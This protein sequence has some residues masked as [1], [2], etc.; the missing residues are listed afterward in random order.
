M[1]KRPNCI[2]AHY[3][4]SCQHISVAAKGAL[5]Q[6]KPQF[7]EEY[8]QFLDQR[9]QAKMQWV[10]DPN[11]S[12]IDNLNNGRREASRHC[13]NKKKEYLKATIEELKTNS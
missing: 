5:Q 13:K 3:V 11:Q 6:H 10:L 12:N 4:F 2:V 9:K 8:L 7:D 1:T